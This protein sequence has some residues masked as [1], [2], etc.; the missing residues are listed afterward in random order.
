MF[1]C[2]FCKK[3]IAEVKSYITHL[4]LLHKLPSNNFNFQCTICPQSF[5]N[6]HAFR[7]H[8]IRHSD[9]NH[10]Q[11]NLES[12]QRNCSSPENLQENISIS[13]ESEQSDETDFSSAALKFAL[14][15]GIWAYIYEQ[16]VSC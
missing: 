1:A 12:I 7:R 13:V 2:F 6:I 16:K 3:K 14:R 9:K 10:I 15:L 11:T 4:K 5:Q 8:L